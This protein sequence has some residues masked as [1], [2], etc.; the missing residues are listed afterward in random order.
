MRICRTVLA[1]ALLSLGVHATARAD[2]A[3]SALGSVAAQPV[4]QAQLLK[5]ATGSFA[6]RPSPQ[7]PVTFVPH[8]H[9]ALTLRLMNTGLTL[10]GERVGGP[11]PRTFRRT[12]VN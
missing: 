6:T 7:S 9:D 5:Q 4:A 11:D 3:Q 1:T 8:D 2:A 10:A 12:G